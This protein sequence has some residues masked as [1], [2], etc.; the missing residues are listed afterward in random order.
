MTLTSSSAVI[1][2]GVLPELLIVAETVVV[3]VVKT[4]APPMPTPLEVP[5]AAAE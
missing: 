2:S 4:S 5:C 1:G 3:S